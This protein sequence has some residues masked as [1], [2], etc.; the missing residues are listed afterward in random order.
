VSGRLTRRKLLGT[1]AAAGAALALDP[2]LAL[3]SRERT[4]ARLDFSKLGDGRG[5]P[6]WRSVDVANLRRSEGHG[7]LEA[8]SDVYPN[9]PRAVAFAVDRQIRD[10]RIEAKIASP[11]AAA[12]V[13]LRRSG[14]TSYSAAIYDTRAKAL[15]LV[16]RTHRG[17]EELASTGVGAAQAPVRLRLEARGAHPTRLEATLTG[18]D[19]S[20]SAVSAHD[21]FR[22]L[23]GRGDP[24]V[25]ATADTL[26]DQVEGV[27][28]PFGSS[29]LGLYGTQEGASFLASP[30][31]Q[32]YLHQVRE[33]STAAFREIAVHSHERPHPSP[34]SVVAATSGVPHPGGA[35]LN[36]AT[37]LPAQV[38]VEVSPDRGFRHARTLHPGRT[39]DFSALIASVGELP[40]G[41]RAYWRARVRRKGRERRGPVRSFRVLPRSGESHPVRIAVAACA[42]QFGPIFG[43][44]AATRPDLLIWQGDLNYP[45]TVGPLAQT[46]SGYAGIWRQFLRNP[47]LAPVLDRAAFAA[48][49]D[50]HDYGLQDARADDIPKRGI[51]PWEALMNERVYYRFAAGLA[52]VWVL[53]QRR[54]KDDPG[55]PDT[56]DKTLLG[57]EQRRWLLSTLADSRA[58]FKVICSPCSLFYTDNA[59]DGNWGT[60]FTA[61]RDLV[62]DHIKKHVSGRAI[63][64]TG[65]A[66]DTMVYDRDGV[67][68]AR[69]CPT[70]IPDPRDHPGVEGGMIGGAGVTYADLRS[71]FTVL[72]IHR[73]GGKALMDLKLVRQDGATPYAKRFEQ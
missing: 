10:G 25:L 14:P 23:Q 66:H 7:L 19:G 29:R 52:E 64:V 35:R 37:D 15:A 32:A 49:R 41:K 65:D 54:F 60:G 63:F 46:V 30:A 33:L 21:S 12:G 20:A 56:R 6:D 18:A 69:G 9:D 38:A 72:D 45:D 42:F 3:A 16:R 73:N 43:H 5:W 13:I 51:E 61:E 70:D 71:H 57:T 17:D 24:A 68:E 67:F 26:L 48:Q 58:P 34:A 31:G 44:L 53:D 36:I 47:K 2:Q 11:G 8:G 55:L 4:V 28:P 1:G 27:F 59:R 39:G 40:S 62:L 22:R 50:D